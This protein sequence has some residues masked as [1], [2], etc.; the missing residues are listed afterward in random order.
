ML[1][2]K[3]SLLSEP[4]IFLYDLETTQN[5][6]ASFRLFDP[7]GSI[8][9]ENIIQE[10]Y[11]VTA[12]WKDLGERTV[13]GSTVLDDPARFKANP[14]D[15]YHVVKT[16][17]DAMMG[18]DIIVGHNGDAYDSKYL[19]TR[20]LV[21]GL[22]PLPPF[23]SIDTLKIAKLRF[24]FNSNRLDYLARLLFKDQKVHTDNQLWLDAL[25][26]DEKAIREMFTY[27]KHDVVLLEKVFLKLR[28]YMP[29]YVN[30]Q[31][32]G[33]PV[34]SC[35]RCGSKH[36]Q[37][38]G[39]RRTTTQAYNQFQCQEC[40]GWFRDRHAIKSLKTTVRTI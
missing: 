21:H 32:F 36:I 14:N 13:H 10:R 16:I 37:S 23:R 2:P 11:I 7:H 17:H 31:L 12:A 24:L 3:E 39:I 29:D 27:N 28:P 40:G 25:K 5:I 1:R 22:S 33:H 19:E 9:H 18:A 4:R 30:H 35:P 34:G 8:P 6:V 26:G 20:I 15:D 38:R